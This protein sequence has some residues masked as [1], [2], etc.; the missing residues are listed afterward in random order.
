MIGTPNREEKI[1]KESGDD[2]AE[3]VGGFLLGHFAGGDGEGFV[4]CVMLTGKFAAA[5]GDQER[6]RGRKGGAFVPVEEC[7]VLGEVEEVRSGHRGEIIM[8]K[9]AGK[10]LSG[11]HDGGGEEAE[12]AHP[13]EAAVAGDHAFMNLKDVFNAEKGDVG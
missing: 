1:G 13:R 9:R 6:E 2:S 8:E 5:I 4:R 12:I 11:G 3:P 10:C 7:V